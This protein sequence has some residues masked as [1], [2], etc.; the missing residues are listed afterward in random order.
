MRSLDGMEASS[1]ATSPMQDCVI[2]SNKIATPLNQAE[3]N[4]VTEVGQ[5]DHVGYITRL[6]LV[7]PTIRFR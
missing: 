7:T 1:K 2:A 4:A 6:F 3:V 5:C